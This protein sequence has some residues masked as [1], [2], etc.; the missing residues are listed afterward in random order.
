MI[1]ALKLPLRLNFPE[2]V[3]VPLITEFVPLITELL[4]LAKE[5]LKLSASYWS[6]IQSS[7]KFASALWWI[8]IDGFSTKFSQA[9]CA[10]SGNEFRGWG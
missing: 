4:S 3:F 6:R 7:H 8:R 5:P 1:I 2:T 10:A 9:D